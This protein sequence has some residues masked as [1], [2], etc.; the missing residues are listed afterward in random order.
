MNKLTWIVLLACLSGM[1]LV[2]GCK[3]EAATVAEKEVP[4]AGL[5]VPEG[6][7]GDPPMIPHEVA[8]SDGGAECLEC[9]KD[10]LDGAPK[11][12]AW[13]DTLTDCR[14]C[15]ALLDESAEAFKVKYH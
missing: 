5:A 13:H 15:H 6:S 10:G 4:K 8:A 1:L 7:T 11:Y 9:H 2:S 14:Q 3:Q 12:P